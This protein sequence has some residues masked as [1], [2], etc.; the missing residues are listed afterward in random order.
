MSCER[1][2][3]GIGSK[4]FWTLCSSCCDPYVAVCGNMTWAP[5]GKCGMRNQGCCVIR[6]PGTQLGLCHAHLSY[7]QKQHTEQLAHHL[8][9]YLFSVLLCCDLLCFL[10][11]GDG[12]LGFASRASWGCNRR[13]AESAE[14][15]LWCPAK[16]PRTRENRH[17]VTFQVSQCRVRRCRSF[18]PHSAYSDFSISV[19]SQ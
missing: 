17:L 1:F 7:A 6:I 18:H 13:G 3:S 4:L 9:V 14:S 5:R 19:L 8:P 16:T 2:V 15:F 10:Q 12:S 11:Q